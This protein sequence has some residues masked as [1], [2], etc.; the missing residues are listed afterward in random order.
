M[1]IKDR[2]TLQFTAL[3]ALILLVFCCTIIYIAEYQREK[4]FNNKLREKALNTVR[5]LIEVNEI[6]VELLKK[7]RRNYF[8]SLPEEFVRVYDASNNR[9]FKDDTFSFRLPR[10]H[11]ELVRKTQKENFTYKSRQIVALSYD[12][13]N[14]VVAAS[15]IDREGKAR[16]WL[17]GFIMLVVY[18]ISLIVIF[19]SGRLF[20]KN[21]LKPITGIIEQ[22]RNITIS[23]LHL[24]V[25][26]GKNN[27]EISM[28]ANEFNQ[29]FSK[30]EYA[31]EMQKR[32][33][34]NASHELRTP[35]TSIIGE[36]SVVLMKDR[37]KKEYRQVLASILEESQKLRDLS[38]NLLNLAQAGIDD[39][40][41][42]VNQIPVT[43]LVSNLK[44]DLEKR[45]S[46]LLAKFTFKTIDNIEEL[47]IYGN[48]AL[49][50]MAFMNVLDNAFKF[51]ENKPVSIIVYQERSWITFKITDEGIG[52]S[53]KEIKN[54]FQPFFRSET[55]QEIPGYGIG[56]SLVQRVITLHGGEIKIISEIHKGT[57]FIIK[58]PLSMDGLRSH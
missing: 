31:F 33:V 7:L 58:L 3:V 55:S 21:S 16:I 53:E 6:D 41:T 47:N 35:L 5:L 15:A 28:L 56:L 26:E 50:S 25:D 45:N 38:N 10:E 57:S 32:F 40:L 9:I 49:L 11:I 51:S 13:G 2:L 42:D 34:S 17:L 19:F 4:D 44:L 20:A 46:S 52:I 30:V 22:V 39:K 18:L 36:V 29:L 1:K 27:D 23:K 12:H 14:Y 54:I 24:R 43:D 37:D 8:L 48:E